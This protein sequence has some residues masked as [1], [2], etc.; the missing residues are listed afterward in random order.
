MSAPTLAPALVPVAQARYPQ[1]CAF[2]PAHKGELVDTQ[3]EDEGFGHVY[4]CVDCVAAWAALIGWTS[5]D[6]ADEL[7]AEA[8][9]L[10]EQLASAEAEEADAEMAQSAAYA[11]IAQGVAERILAAMGIP[12]PDDH[13]REA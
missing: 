9:R 4:V 1:R 5:P 6:D 3:I 13:S 12:E 7:R 10:R 8:V 11:E 2:C